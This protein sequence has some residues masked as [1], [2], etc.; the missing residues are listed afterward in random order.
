MFSPEVTM[1]NDGLDLEFLLSVD[2][3]WGWSREVVAV[4]GSFPERRQEAGMKYVMD[5]PDWR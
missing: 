3:V 4:L 2:D 5:G 1:I